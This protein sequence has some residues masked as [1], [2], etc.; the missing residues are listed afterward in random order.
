MIRSGRRPFLP[1]RRPA[2]TA[3][4][5][6]ALSPAPR[7]SGSPQGGLHR[8][9]FLPMTAAEQKALGRAA[10]I[11]LVSGVVRWGFEQ[12]RGPPVQVAGREDQLPRLLEE[13]RAM[14]DEEERRSRPLDPGE[15]LDLNGAP[16]P[17]LDRLPGVGPATARAIVEARDLRGGFRRVDD[18]V[19][20][21]GIGPA[22]LDKIRLHLEVGPMPVLA[23]RGVAGGSGGSRRGPAGEG[24]GGS[25]GAGGAGGATSGARAPPRSVPVTEAPPP[26]L[27]PPP[28]RAA[29]GSAAPASGAAGATSGPPGGVGGGAGA[30]PAAGVPGARGGSASTS[31]NI[32]T[33]T[34]AELTEL[35][36]I[37]P[38][39]AE[40]IVTERQRRGGFRS[41]D[42]LVEV[43]GIGPATLERLRAKAR[44]R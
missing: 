32:N 27:A 41:V 8:P 42:E 26:G 2:F 4:V 34:E 22:T 28:A 16:E 30:G 5:G 9:A 43:R 40:R 38:A 1:S 31:I 14:R 13:A 10:V 6:H 20:V 36:G 17:E 25:P 39:L 7:P 21:R 19:E 29:T 35:P 33:A 18:L 12:Y 3:K 24:G 23:G 37:G 44:V 15:T 11:L